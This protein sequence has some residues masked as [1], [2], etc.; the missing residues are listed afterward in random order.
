MPV[1]ESNWS[2]LSETTKI[3]KLWIQTQKNT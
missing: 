1:V 3:N 2:I